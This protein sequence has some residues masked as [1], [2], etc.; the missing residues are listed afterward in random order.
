MKYAGAD[1]LAVF[2][3]GAGFR[4]TTGKD[5]GLIGNGIYAGI[6]PNSANIVEYNQYDVTVV[7]D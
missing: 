1:Q 7:D 4:D 3:G 2:W 5:K 6:S